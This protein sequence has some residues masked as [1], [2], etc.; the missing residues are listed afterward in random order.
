MSTCEVQADRIVVLP[1]TDPPECG[2]YKPPGQV[3]LRCRMPATVGEV[4]G[5]D[6]YLW[7]CDDCR[8]ESLP[9]KPIVF[10]PDHRLG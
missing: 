8:N 9:S 7:R 4:H 1:T 3:Y 2:A 10:H 5:E 6:H